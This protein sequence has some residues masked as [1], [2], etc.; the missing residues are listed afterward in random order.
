MSG[1][2]EEGGGGEDGK[3]GL[4]ARLANS[5]VVAVIRRY[6]E[7]GAGNWAAAIALNA[8]LSLFPILLAILFIVSLVLRDP[9]TRDSVLQQIARVLPP[10]SQG[11]PNG[12]FEQIRQAIDGVRSRTGLLGAITLPSLLWGGSALFGCI[13]S[14]FAAIHGFTPRPFLAQKLMAVGMIVAYAVLSVVG[15]AASTMLAVLTPVAQQVGVDE[16][17]GGPVRY[18][19]QVG[20]GLL[21]G[22]ALFGLIHVVIPR[23]HPDRPRALP[24]TILGAVGFELLTLAWPLYF[25]LAGSGANRYGQVFGLLLLLVAYVVF[26]AQILVIGAVLNNVV[27]ARQAATQRPAVKPAEVPE[28]RSPPRQAV[29]PEPVAD[30][31]RPAS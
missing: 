27:T 12:T 3:Q 25:R 24:G 20:V 6:G 30:T 13:E 18:L 4:R 8:L 31:A 7:V 1:E 17:L 15:I 10:D 26:L 23:R 21:V 19:I 29:G 16:V 14:A 2:R 11:D 9:G 5:L 22:A 28:L